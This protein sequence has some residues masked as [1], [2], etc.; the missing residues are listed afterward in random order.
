M[1]KNWVQNVKNRAKGVRN[2]A[3]SMGMKWSPSN[4]ILADP[5]DKEEVAKIMRRRPRPDAFVCEND[6]LAANL[7]CSLQDLGYAVPDD[8]MITGFDDIQIARI[9]TPGITTIRQ[10]YEALAKAAFE[11]LQKR[12]LEYPVDPVQIVCPFKFIERDSTKRRG[13]LSKTKRISKQRR[14]Q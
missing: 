11:R 2:V 3:L 4:V 14:S 5:A 10:P 12:M 9:A 6:V 1:R 7:M 8:V 13:V